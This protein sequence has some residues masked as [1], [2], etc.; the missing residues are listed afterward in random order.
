MAEHWF[1]LGWA[2][3]RGAHTSCRPVINIDGSV[4]SVRLA[5]S[6][7]ED[8]SKFTERNVGSEF[9][10]ELVGSYRGKFVITSAIDDGV[11]ILSSPTVEVSNSAEEAVNKLLA[12]FGE[13]N[14]KLPDTDPL[15]VYDKDKGDNN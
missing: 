6:D 13:G 14:V 1:N 10:L 11:L 8:F 5:N 4:T 15:S 3:L 9:D 2:S 12:P 7:I